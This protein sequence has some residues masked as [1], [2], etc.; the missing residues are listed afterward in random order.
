MED[1]LRTLNISIVNT[2]SMREGGMQRGIIKNL[3]R[4][5]TH[6]AEVQ[7][8]HITRDANYIMGNYRVIATAATKS[9]TTG[10]VQGRVTVM[11]HES[12]QP[13][14]TQITRERRSLRVTLGRKYSKMPIRILS[15]YAP[16]NG[17]KDEDRRHHWDGA[18][19][20]L[21]KTCK[22]HMVMWRTESNGQLGLGG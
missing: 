11:I 2:D 18:N 6:I 8:T 14:T 17:R 16:R 13:N 4:N 3:A 10:V 5:K 12:I 22:R 7:E 9:E 1:G 19:A 21:D 15:T 20:T